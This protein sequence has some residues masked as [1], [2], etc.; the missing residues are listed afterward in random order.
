MTGIRHVMSK[1]PISGD[2]CYVMLNGLKDS[3]LLYLLVYHLRWRGIYV[4]TN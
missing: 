3:H 2:L 1:Q 4:T